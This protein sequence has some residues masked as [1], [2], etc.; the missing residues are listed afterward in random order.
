M[1]KAFRILKVATLAAAFSAVSLSSSGHGSCNTFFNAKC[2]GQP[3]WMS[4]SRLFSWGIL[5]AV[6][7]TTYQCYPYP[8]AAYVSRDWGSQYTKYTAGLGCQQSGWKKRWYQSRGEEFSPLVSEF[9]PEMISGDADDEDYSDE[10]N[11]EEAKVSERD[12]TIDYSARTITVSG[13]NAECRV[14]IGEPVYSTIQ[15]EI[16]QGKDADDMDY[17]KSKVIYKTSI[18]VKGM[19]DAIETDGSLGSVSYASSEKD[20]Y[21]NLVISDGEVVIPIPSSADIRYLGL[22]LVSDGGGDEVATIKKA[23]SSSDAALLNGSFSFDVYPNPANDHFTIRLQ[24]KEKSAADIRIYDVTGKLAMTLPAASL[25]AG[26][27]SDITIDAS[28]LVAGTY[29][30]VIQNK[31]K[32]Y[33]KQITAVH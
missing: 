26:Q 2:D 12:A 3:R 15:Y 6:Q 1:K 23:M 33:V 8:A 30:V 17:D 29:Y 13:I 18:T 25:I 4:D 32:K 20:G 31:D 16:W 9:I 22:R 7:T 28:G 5:M 10:P 19:R 21:R 27:A 14:L 24:S 11:S